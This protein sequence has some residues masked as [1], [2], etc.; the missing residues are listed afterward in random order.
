[1]GVTYHTNI[2]RIEENKDLLISVINSYEITE[3][4]IEKIKKLKVEIEA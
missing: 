3:L 4:S 1:M 2:D